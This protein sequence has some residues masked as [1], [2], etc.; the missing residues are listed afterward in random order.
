MRENVGLWKDYVKIEM[1]DP[2]P[3]VTPL[4][5]TCCVMVWGGLRKRG[6][7]NPKYPDKLILES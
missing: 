4:Y 7:M 1:E 5:A 3:H 6:I 2:L